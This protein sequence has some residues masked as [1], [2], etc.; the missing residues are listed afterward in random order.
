MFAR[1]CKPETLLL[2]RD[3]TDKMR[4][5]SYKYFNGV[6]V[7]V[8]EDFELQLIAEKAVYQLLYLICKENYPVT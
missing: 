2:G 3:M 8:S 1:V 4:E 6:D 5:F 7:D